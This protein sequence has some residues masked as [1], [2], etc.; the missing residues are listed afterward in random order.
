MK[1]YL[2]PTEG[3]VT[4]QRNSGQFKRFIHEY[5]SYYRELEQDFLATRKYV[6]FDPTNY[7][8]YS[9]EY[10]K[11]F[12]ATC[13]EVDVLGKAMAYT[14]NNSFKPDDKKNNIYKWWFEIQDAYLLPRKINATDINADTTTLSDSSCI[15]LN[16]ATLKPWNSFR[17]EWSKNKKGN[18]IIKRSPGSET[19]SW[20]TS[21][22][23]VKHHRI[24][25]AANSNSKANYHEANLGNVISA[26]AALYILEISYMS[27]IGTET[28][29]S[30]FADY[31]QLFERNSNLTPA[32]IDSWFQ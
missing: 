29:L 31:S 16:D 4:M 8:T 26:F 22:N 7:S 28:D 11:L 21:Y 27:S 1:A 17:T 5:W 13:S 12:Q 24:S 6:S 20:W 18:N 30:A 2:A 32:E 14:A 9:L 19:P 3:I 10:L 23:N 25:P 15:F